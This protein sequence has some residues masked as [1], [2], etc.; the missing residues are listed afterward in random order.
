LRRAP[1]AAS[2]CEAVRFASEPACKAPQIVAIVPGHDGWVVG[3]VPVVLIEFDFKGDT[4]ARFGMPDAHVTD[5]GRCAAADPT[6]ATGRPRARGVFL[7]APQGVHVIDALAPTA[8]IHSLI[9]VTV[10]LPPFET[11][12]LLSTGLTVAASGAGPTARYVM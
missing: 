4:I 9:T 2:S 1:T 7:L 11:Y 8:G 5:H 10:P 12:T 3:T 6:M